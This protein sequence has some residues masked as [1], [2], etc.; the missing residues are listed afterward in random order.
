MEFE[1]TQTEADGEHTYIARKFPLRNAEGRIYAL[2]AICT[3]VTERKAAEQALRHS[4]ED[5]NHAQAVAQTGSWRLDVRRNELLWSDETYRIFGI[6]RGTPLTY[7]TFLLAVHPEDR[8][9]VDQK[10]KAALQGRAL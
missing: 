3:D 6:P 8:A 7:E 4:R 2:C 5:L 1:E 10:W 9:L